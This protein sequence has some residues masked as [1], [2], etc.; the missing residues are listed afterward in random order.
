M[1]LRAK[2][3]LAL[4]LISAG[5]TTASLVIVRRIVSGHIRAQIVQDLQNSIATFD[6]VRREREMNLSRSA[7]LMADLPIVR[8]LMTTRHPATIQDASV[9]L[10]HT[11]G[12]D[13]LVLSDAA[14]RVMAVQSSASRLQMDDVQ[15]ALSSSQLPGN[16]VQWWLCG[17]RLFEVA[18]RP[19]YLGNAEPNHLMGFIALGSEI[20]DKV[21][22]ELS[23][24]AGSEVVFRGGDK[25]ARSTLVPKQESQLDSQ[26]GASVSVSEPR[27]V[28]LEGERFLAKD[29][30]LSQSPASVQLTVL[31][32]LDQSNAF[33]MSLDKFFVELGVLGTFAGAVLVWIISRTITQPLR[34]LVSGVRALAQ[35]DFEYPLERQ[36]G[37]DEVAE[38]T[39]AFQRMRA[40]LQN[41][42]NKLLDSERLAT[43]GRMASSISH[44]LRHHLVAIVSNAEFLIDRRR[45][46]SEREELYTEID[47]AVHEMNDLV[48]S[49]LEFSRTRESL[50]L[51][52]GHVDDAIQAAI[53]LIRLRPE[54]KNIQIEVNSLD[55]SEGVFDLKKLERVFHNLLLNACEAVSPS[56]GKVNVEICRDRAHIQVRVR[57]NGRGIPEDSRNKIFQPFFTEG[58][59][60]G[61]GLGLTVAQKIV[62]D[63]GGDL[64]IESS[65]VQG[66]VFLVTLPAHAAEPT[67]NTANGQRV[68]TIQP[69]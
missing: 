50:R 26:R 15:A 24:V 13:L 38:L 16:S 25:L 22:H 29:I 34:S 64:S 51:N 47:A 35:S 57:D 48:D 54:F 68:S 67:E 46:N 20:D 17:Q 44:D 3:L 66:T 62:Q 18:I 55:S 4:L 6:N 1:T 28:T 11:S 45:S 63:H 41:S 7:D 59:A 23:Q 37:N 36:R 60:N 31:K 12:N 9:E 32:S 39:T 2:F 61:T 65:S 8:A 49:L 30:E 10:W 19:I 69:G 40:D 14:G 21:A 56:T 33:L 42:Q 5:L 58:K 52:P 53:R 43:I 27:E